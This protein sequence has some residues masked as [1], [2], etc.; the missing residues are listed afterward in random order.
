MDFIIWEVGEGEGERKTIQGTCCHFS[1]VIYSATI[2]WSYYVW[3]CGRCTLGVKTGVDGE[4]DHSSRGVIY[5]ERRRGLGQREACA[6][7]VGSRRH[8]S[9][10]TI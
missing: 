5:A 7:K 10:S 2:L 8:V 9:L 1:Y 3:I 6:R 4:G